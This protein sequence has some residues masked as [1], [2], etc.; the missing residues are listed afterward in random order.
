VYVGSHVLLI[1]SVLSHTGPVSGNP[2]FYS[3]P[4]HTKSPDPSSVAASPAGLHHIL[5]S[6]THSVCDALEAP[7]LQ[8][9]S[10]WTVSAR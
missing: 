7:Q 8:S 6:S 3:L 5:R 4:S 10:P 9:T 2:A 1:V